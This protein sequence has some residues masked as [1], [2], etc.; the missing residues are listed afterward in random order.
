MLYYSHFLVLQ[1]SIHWRSREGFNIP[2]GRKLSR[3]KTFANFA[4]LCNATKVFSANILGAWDTWK[5]CGT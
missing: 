4:N 3:E 1:E 2:Y 5:G